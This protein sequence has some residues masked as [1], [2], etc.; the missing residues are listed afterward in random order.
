MLTL[1]PGI[2]LERITEFDPFRL[3]LDVLFPRATLDALAPVRDWLEPWHVDFASGEV[4]LGMQS[5]LLRINGRVVLID[6]CVGDHKERP[7][8]AEWHHRTGGDYL[9]RLA[10]AGVMPQDVDVV[11]C[12]HL[13][14]DHA[15]WNTRLADGRWQPTFPNARYLVGRAELAH[16]AAIEA[17][18]PG[19]VGHGV[20]ADS[21]QPI[22]DAGLMEVVDDGADLGPRVALETGR[23]TCRDLAGH[24]P[25]Q[26]GLELTHAAGRAHFCGDAVHSVLQLHRPDISSRF[27]HDGEQ[28]HR[29][30]LALFDRLAGTD[31]LL[32]PAHL[33]GAL[34]LRLRRDGDAWAPDLVAPWP[35]C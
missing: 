2:T 6:T 1:G 10:A 18:A 19:S 33:R 24:S 7:R 26:M 27:C 25:G 30:R 35:M 17:R 16:W 34:A 21:V 32:I 4:L 13:H 14:A 31:D 5:H 8:R 28:A 29:C 9:R 22:L 11:F 12:T 15:G 20:F 3:P 23:L